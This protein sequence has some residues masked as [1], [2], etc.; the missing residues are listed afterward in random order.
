MDLLGVRTAAVVALAII[1]MPWQANAGEGKVRIDVAYK[2]TEQGPLGL[3]LHYPAGP[4]PKTGYP[5]V[6]FTHGGGWAKGS[7]TI[8][9]KGGRFEA[10]NALNKAGFC[11]AS[12]HYRLCTKDGRIVMRDCIIDSKDALRYLAKN[13]SALS[14]DSKSVFTFGDS[15]GGH[16][17]QMVLLS[18]PESFPGDPKLANAS[19]RLLG[20]VSWYGPCDFEKKNL[21]LK[22]DGTGNVDRFKD[23]ILRGDENPEQELAAVREISPVNYLKADMPPLLMLQGDQDTTIPVHHAHYMKERAD[24]V[25]APVTKLIVKNASHGWKQ[26]GDGPMSMTHEEIVDQTVRFMLGHLNHKPSAVRQKPNIVHII[27]DELGYYELSSMGHAEMQTPNI[28]KLAEEGT[29]FTQML[30][31]APACA[32][33]RCTLMTGKHSGHGSVRGNSGAAPLLAGEETIASVLKREGYATGGF[34]KW[35]VGARGTSGVPEKHGF[36]VFYGYYDQVHAHTYYP[37]YLIRNSEEVVLPGNTGDTKIGKT[38]AHYEIYKESMDFIRKNKDGP[39]YLYLPW[40]PPHGHWGLPADEPSLALYK[41]RDWPEDAKIYASMVNMVDRQVGEIRVLLEELGLAENTLILFTGDNGGSPYFKSKAAPRGIFAPNIDPKT[42]AEFRGAK[43]SLYEGGLRVPAIVWWPGK[44]EA[45]RVSDHLCYFPDVLPTF[46]EMAGADV[47]EGIDG[48]SFLPEL[49]GKSQ[50]Q[51]TYL[52]WEYGKHVA[53]RMGLWKAHRGNDEQ[54]WQLFD[55]SRDISE[56]T[57]VSAQHP[58]VLKI[59][60][61]YAKE[62]HTAPV[63][64]E[65]Y[66]PELAAKDK[67]YKPKSTK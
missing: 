12:V 42:G 37:R 47:P 17:A 41:D 60:R 55:L 54:T 25:A 16:I 1:T 30:A 44:V 34:G 46:A 32:P 5:L 3:D 18:P 58:K 38:H 53:V 52:Y 67:N 56:T 9:S 24:L 27:L 51:H 31:G 62:A 10:V 33:T 59:M 57:D 7:K 2:K 48:I 4:A 15:A 26:R 8:G 14:L 50:T 20:G 49:L 22:P 6:I 28:D 36:D 40:T 66:N 13:A 43:R 23:R 63:K 35:G 19:F 39:F 64:G 29:R 45:D 11:V 65:I 61:A 21:F